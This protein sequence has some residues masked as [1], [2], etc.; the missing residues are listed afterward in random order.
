MVS[1]QPIKAAPES[2]KTPGPRATHS[3]VFD[4]QQKKV[5]LLDG[6]YPAIQPQQS[7]IWSW[8]GNE[9]TR[10]DST[11]PT[12]R[13]AAASVYDI[14]RR[15]IVT[16]G[17]RVG[18]NEKIIGDTWEWDGSKWHQ[19][20][21]SS[22][23]ARDHQSM[24][25]DLKDKATV[26]FGGTVFPRRPG[27]WATDTWKW[28]G[29][30]WKQVATD[31]PIGRVAPMVYDEKRKQV[32]LFGG[33]GAS[34]E[35]GKAQ[36][37]YNDTWAWDGRQWKMLSDHGPDPR[38]RHALAYD[39]K[40]ELIILYGGSKEKKIFNDMW[41]WNGKTWTEIKLS[42]NTPGKRCLHAMTYDSSRDKIILYGGNNG[43]TVTGDTW[44]WD[45]KQW[46]KKAD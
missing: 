18:K 41:K 2:N 22:L 33:V 46:T 34:S 44:E 16:N 15:R 28:N 36:P 21:D 7:E 45:G 27:P 1:I 39:S 20:V 38:D 5:L 11:G 26:M 3:L 14:E 30:N 4:E 37:D 17:G 23:T 35:R 29:K 42:G 43:E 9:W 25:Y 31:G 8:D 13:Y 40:R 19:L 10:I 24:V 12:P 32:V 6:Y